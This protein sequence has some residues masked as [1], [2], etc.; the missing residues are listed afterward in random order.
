M[1]G[2]GREGTERE[3]AGRVRSVWVEN[4]VNTL[5]KEAGVE[6]IRNGCSGES[7]NFLQCK[8]LTR[9]SQCQSVSCTYVSLLLAQAYVTSSVS[10]LVYD[11]LPAVCQCLSASLSLWRYAGHVSLSVCVTGLSACEYI[12]YTI[13]IR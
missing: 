13:I 8:F 12:Q 7:I 4:A 11:S 10:L 2:G 5:S 1:G 9:H 6:F 3:M